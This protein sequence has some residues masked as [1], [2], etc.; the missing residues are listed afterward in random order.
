MGIRTD[1]VA[2]VRQFNRFYT[3]RLG[4]LDQGHLASDF[5]L[6]EVRV[7]YELAHREGVTARVLAEELAVDAGYLSRMLASFTRR[8]LVAKTRSVADAR[9]VHLALSAHGRKTFAALDARAND[10]V[11]SLLASL[12]ARERP[13]LVKAMGTVQAI[14]DAGASARGAEPDVLRAHRPGDMGWVTQRHGEFYFSE[15]GWDERFEALVAR[16]CADFIDH[17]D[18]Q[19]ERCWIAE[20]DGASIGSVFL[21]RH[22]EQAN[23]ARLRLL[24]VE[25]SARGLGVG[26]RLVRECTTFARAAGYH[27]VT[28]WTNDV[29]HS[30]RR[31]YQ[32]EGYQLVRE[33]RHRSFGHDLVG[34]T[35]DLVL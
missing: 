2:R 5:S 8:R 31:I 27:T 29:L 14:L 23:V 34:Q 24:F 22:P 19:R 13:V 35:W 11:R 10:S 28:L 16:I 4:L 18:P 33:E 21:V 20:Q 9:E 32:A 12:Q 3:R 1:D 15:Y 7:M 30:A 17:L 26:R 25:P 6:T